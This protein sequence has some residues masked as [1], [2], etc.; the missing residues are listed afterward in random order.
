MR[1]INLTPAVLHARARIKSVGYISA[2]DLASYLMSCTVELGRLSGWSGPSEEFF[3]TLCYGGIH[4]V[5]YTNELVED[6]RLKD[7]FYYNPSD[8][9]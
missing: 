1:E 5:S 6:Y 9:I 4:R 2:I 8:M 7:L 3:D